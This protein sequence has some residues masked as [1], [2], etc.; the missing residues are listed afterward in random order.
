MDFVL[1][2]WFYGMRV[3]MVAIDSA[4]ATFPT[5]ATTELRQLE[6]YIPDLLSNVF[7]R[8]HKKPLSAISFSL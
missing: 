1:C 6:G 8:H 7:K 4:F 2:A 3:G 5:T